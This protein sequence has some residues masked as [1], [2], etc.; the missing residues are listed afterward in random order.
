MIMNKGNPAITPSIVNEPLRALPRA[1]H[2]SIDLHIFYC[3]R[4]LGN[5]K[6]MAELLY[7][8]LQYKLILVNLVRYTSK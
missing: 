3:K 4:K 6:L 8:L 1:T 7:S 2:H 5:D